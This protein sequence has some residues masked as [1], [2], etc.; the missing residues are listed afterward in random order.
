VFTGT[1]HL[2]A[3]APNS[4]PGSTSASQYAWWDDENYVAEMQNGDTAHC[5]RGG[6]GVL[7]FLGLLQNPV[8][9]SGKREGTVRFA[10]PLRGSASHPDFRYDRVS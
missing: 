5:E 4:I 7:G 8:F 3:L 10:A 6:D 2:S 1:Q 9:R